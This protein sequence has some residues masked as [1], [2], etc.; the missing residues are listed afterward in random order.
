MLKMRVILVQ[1]GANLY[2]CICQHMWR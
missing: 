1:V 2:G